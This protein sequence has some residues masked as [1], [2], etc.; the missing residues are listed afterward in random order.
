MVL[1]MEPRSS[2]GV[3]SSSPNRLP[4]PNSLFPQVPDLSLRGLPGVLTVWPAEAAQLL[5]Q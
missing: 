3:C 2:W 4:L 1:G 5:L